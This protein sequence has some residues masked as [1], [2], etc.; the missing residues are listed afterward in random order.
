MLIFQWLL[1]SV[2]SEY[3]YGTDCN[4]PCGH[5]KDKD[6]CDNTTG[7][8]PNGCQNQWTGDRCE[9][10][11]VYTHFIIFFLSIANLFDCALP[12]VFCFTIR[13]IPLSVFQWIISIL[14]NKLL[15]FKIHLS[16]FENK[17]I[18]IIVLQKGRFICFIHVPN[19]IFLRLSVIKNEF[20]RCSATSV[21]TNK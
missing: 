10:E 4:T 7:H 1:S 11:I 2:C 15:V 9:G 17:T 14:K 20:Y 16:Y 12:P 18:I 13:T 5:C 3:I 19:I 21:Q 8:C 6:V